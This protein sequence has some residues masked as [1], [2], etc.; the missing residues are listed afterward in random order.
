MLLLF[1]LGWWLTISGLGLIA[2]SQ[3]VLAVEGQGRHLVCAGVYRHVRNPMWL[4]ALLIAAG[5]SLTWR[6]WWIAGAG[7]A[8]W[9]AANWLVRRREEPALLAQHGESF[10]LYQQLVP[11]W[12]PRWQPA[13]GCLRAA[14]SDAPAPEKCC[15]SSGED[16]TISTP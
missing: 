11:R 15:A 8:L 3:R 16:C 7:L 2:S 10:K 5:Q 4:G 6:S 12:I 1:M 14:G 9:L 13:T